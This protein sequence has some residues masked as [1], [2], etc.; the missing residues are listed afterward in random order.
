VLTAAHCA[1]AD[2]NKPSV[3]RLGEQNLVVRDVGSPEVDYEI[4]EF[5]NHENYDRDT[6]HNDIA[7]IR[8]ATDVKFTKFIRPACLYPSDTITKKSAIASGWG[9][10]EVAGPT[11]DELLKVELD[12]IPNDRCSA[13]FNDESNYNIDNTQ[14]CA[15][16]LQVS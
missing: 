12:I 7:L 3:V 10:T 14:L 16:V 8:L 2:R 1:F 13:I 4:A 15:G 9:Y 6:K 11:S 5:I